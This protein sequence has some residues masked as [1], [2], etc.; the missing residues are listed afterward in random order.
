MADKE[1][2]LQSKDLIIPVY[3]DTGALL[4]L[5]AS[6]EGGFSTVQKVTTTNTASEAV[7]VANRSLY[8]EVNIANFIKIGANP[9]KKT[10]SSGETGSVLE[11]ERYQTY[12]SLFYRLRSFLTE[13][14]LLQVVDDN[15]QTWKVIQPSDFVEVRGIFSPNPFGDWLSIVDRLIPLIMSANE[16]EF[17]SLQGQLESFNSIKPIKQTDEDKAKIQ[18]LSQ[19]IQTKKSEIAGMVGIRSILAGF[20]GDVEKEDT[21]VFIVDVRGQS[22]YQIVVNL[23]T[24]YLRD[25]STAELANKSFV[26]LGKVIQ[27]LD[28]DN[29]GSIK[30]LKGTGLGGLS[31]SFLNN[32]FESVNNSTGEMFDLPKIF[33]EVRSPAMQLV[34]IA[35]YI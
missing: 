17:Q 16:N 12:G 25:R 33:T 31:S 5:I 32:L 2:A 23:F 6:I 19:A 11:A 24:E 4:D 18:Q 7:N 8:A 10:E 3:L 1:S 15:A 13:K 9:A 20:K 28:S 30:L 21:R 27:K 29:D 22:P 26:V 35:I 14:K 34:P